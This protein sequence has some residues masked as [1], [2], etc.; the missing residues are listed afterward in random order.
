MEAR[1]VYILPYISRSNDDR[2]TNPT[3]TCKCHGVPRVGILTAL[4]VGA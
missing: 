4:H 2:I 1:N 3:N